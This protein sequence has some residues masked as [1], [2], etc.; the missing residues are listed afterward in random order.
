MRVVVMVGGWKARDCLH[1]NNNLKKNHS[2]SN[3]IFQHYQK[4][5]L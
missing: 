1:N 4:T 2:Y 3:T 5:Q